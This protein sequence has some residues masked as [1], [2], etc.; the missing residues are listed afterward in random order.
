MLALAAVCAARAPP[1]ASA[2]TVPIAVATVNGKPILRSDVETRYQDTLGE[3]H[4][5][6]SKEQA[7]IVRLNIVRELIDDEIV[8]AARRQAEPCRDRRG[9]RQTG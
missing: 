4:Q 9:G 3:S 1:A 8:D 2:A 5:K 7:D 6:P